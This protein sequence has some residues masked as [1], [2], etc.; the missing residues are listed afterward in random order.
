MPMNLAELTPIAADEEKAFTLLESILWPNGAI[1]P[2]C[3][4]GDRCGKLPTQRTKASKKH[5]EGKPVYGLW[6]CYRCRKQFT[7]RVNTIFE[8]SHIPLGKWL[9][10]IHAMCSSKKGVSASQLQRELG[11]TYKSAWFMCHRV[12]VAMTEKTLGPKLGGAG[13]SRIVEADETYVG[14]KVSNNMHKNKTAEAGKKHIVLTMV[15]RE[16]RARTF[17]IPDTG[18]ETLKYMPIYNVEGTAHIVTD[19]HASYRGLDKHFASHSAVDH[20]KEYV[21]GV[22]HTNFAESYHSLL[23]RGIVGTFHHI[24]EKHLPRY[25]REFEFR[26]NSRKDTD[27]ERTEAAIRGAEGKRL[28]YAAPK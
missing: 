17:L 2:N 9:L 1:C 16:G 26:W 19:S 13:T 11:L 22:V 18:R 8:D 24:S 23:K 3:S 12:R 7:V 20:S 28:Q 5:P 4:Q 10:A 21:R 15:E 6:K 25:L 27:G 14:G